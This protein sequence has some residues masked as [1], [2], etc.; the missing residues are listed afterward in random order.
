M[1]KNPIAFSSL[2]YP[3]Q[4]LFQSRDQ[5]VLASRALAL[6]KQKKACI[7][8]DLQFFKPFF[9]DDYLAN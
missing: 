5:D 8:A 4:R 3:A 1:V 2:L 6:S 9:W 7:T